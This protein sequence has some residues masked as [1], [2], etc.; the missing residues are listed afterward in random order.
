MR[1]AALAIPLSIAL[2]ATPALAHRG[3]DDGHHRGGDAPTA[4]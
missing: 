2:A 4:E 3:A 1:K